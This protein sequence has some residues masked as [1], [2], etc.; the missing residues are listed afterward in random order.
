MRYT[1]GG[2]GKIVRSYQKV[3]KTYRIVSSV[4][5]TYKTQNVNIRN[6]N[7][8]NTIRTSASV[9]IVKRIETYRKM[10]NR[11]MV[12]NVLSKWYDSHFVNGENDLPT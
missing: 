4:R 5:F 8:Q 6:V 1:A 10:E 12:R 11:T 7:I 3:E 9:R 2:T